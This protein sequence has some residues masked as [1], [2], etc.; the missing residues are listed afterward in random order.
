MITLLERLKAGCV[1]HPKRWSGDCGEFSRVDEPETDKLLLSA[2]ER[3]EKLE[4]VLRIISSLDFSQNG[5]AQDRMAR[6]Q[7]I[8]ME[9]L[10]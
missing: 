9:A 3:I 2:A 5:S 4:N 8:A 1:W 10:K 6:A 7:N